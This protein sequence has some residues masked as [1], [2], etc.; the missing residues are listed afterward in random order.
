V[1]R[2]SFPSQIAQRD[3]SRDVTG[4]AK[5]LGAATRCSYRVSRICDHGRKDGERALR[6]GISLRD[7][8][9]PATNMSSQSLNSTNLPRIRFE[10]ATGRMGKCGKP[11][12]GLVWWQ[13]KAPCQRIGSGAATLDA[14]L[15]SRA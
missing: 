2:I 7:G 12:P 14:V 5:S 1:R 11:A 10:P 15:A 4:D 13:S 6:A 9:F 8:P 3:R